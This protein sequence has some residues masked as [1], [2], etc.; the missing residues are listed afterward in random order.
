[1]S[2]IK[3][4]VT[5]KVL[6]PQQEV[7]LKHFLDPKSET[8]GNYL[9]SSLKAGYSQEYAENIS[10]LMP[11]WLEETLE[12]STLVRKALD[13]LSDFIGNEKNPT[14]Q[15]DATKFTLKNLASGKFSERQE[16]TGKG[17]KDLIPETLTDEDKKAL[18]GLIKK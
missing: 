5:W 8:F 14:I 12:D 9:Q 11:K 1:M 7:F 10:S 4:K 15:W 13:N 16:V 6:N 18:L 2:K 17:G 3:E